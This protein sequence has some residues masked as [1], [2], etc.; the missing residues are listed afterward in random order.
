MDALM[1][2]VEWMMLSHIQSLCSVGI[3][4]R[5]LEGRVRSFPPPSPPF[6]PMANGMHG[7]VDVGHCIVVVDLLGVLVLG[8]LIIVG[9]AQDSLLIVISYLV[10]N[11]SSAPKPN[12]QR[13]CWSS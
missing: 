9:V 10:Y 2:I 8:K 6:K 1:K 13:I 7:N 5:W 4:S 3:C 12:T 11:F